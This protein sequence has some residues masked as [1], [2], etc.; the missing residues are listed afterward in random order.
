MSVILGNRDTNVVIQEI[1]VYYIFE[2]IVKDNVPQSQYI[3]TK[4]L[5]APT[6]SQNNINNKN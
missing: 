1:Y 5:N 4:T 2:E 6:L 3:G